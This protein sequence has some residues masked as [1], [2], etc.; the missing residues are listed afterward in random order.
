MG[1]TEMLA[2]LL[3]AMVGALMACALSLVPALH[4]HT[5]AGCF[6]LTGSPL[7][8]HVPAAFTAM[9]LLGAKNIEDVWG[10]D[11]LLLE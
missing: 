8:R 4:I 9:F 5:V 2:M 10:N 6:L 7:V 1:T 11:S 3:A